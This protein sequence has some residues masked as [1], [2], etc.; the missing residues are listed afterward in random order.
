MTKK[1]P[2]AFLSEPV[3]PTIWW[4]ENTTP[5]EYR[6]TVIEAGNKWNEAF[7][8]AGFKN[9]VVMKIQPDD[10]DWDAG[11]VRYNVIRWVASAYPSY[12]AIGPSFAN[13][14]TGQILGSDITIEW[15]SGSSSPSIDELFLLKVQQIQN[16]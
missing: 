9:A 15:A 3:E 6:Q 14:R 5:V 12:G 7:E 1:D 16:T 11:D 2:G 10:A 13:P 4:I 8:K